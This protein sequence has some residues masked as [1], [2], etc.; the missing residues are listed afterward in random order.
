M[1]FATAK[2]YLFGLH[3]LCE[4]ADRHLVNFVCKDAYLLCLRQLR[5]RRFGKTSEQ[6]TE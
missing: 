4:S 5:E 3:H 1:R 2:N 6:I